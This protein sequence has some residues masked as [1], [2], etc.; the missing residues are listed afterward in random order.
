MP[1]YKNVGWIL[2][3]VDKFILESLMKNAKVKLKYLC[4]ITGLTFAPMSNRINALE[5]EYVVGSYAKVDKK[6]LGYEID[7]ILLI[8]L[9]SQSI[10]TLDEFMC[11]AANRPEIRSIDMVTGSCDYI[12]KFV[13]KN[14]THSKEVIEFIRN[15]PYINKLQY[16]EIIKSSL[17]REGVPI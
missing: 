1:K 5:E 12:I 14:S 11:Y 15:S 3:E 17:F 6:K 9:N 10:D 7:G 16:F 4:D 8:S 13:A 2:D